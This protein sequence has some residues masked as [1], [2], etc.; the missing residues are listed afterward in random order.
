MS[1]PNSHNLLYYWLGQQSV[2][3][4]GGG[5]PADTRGC[6]ALFFSALFFLL[7]VIFIFGWANTP[8]GDI[9]FFAG[10]V[11]FGLSGAAGFYWKYWSDNDY[12][13][14]GLSAWGCFYF[15]LLITLVP[16]AI[17]AGWAAA[18]Y[19][20]LYLVSVLVGLWAL[21]M[22]WSLTK[23]WWRHRASARTWWWLLVIVGF[24]FLAGGW[25]NY[26]NGA[27]QR[28]LPVL[29]MGLGMLAVWMGAALV[30]SRVLRT[31][32][33]AAMSRTRQAQPPQFTTD[34]QPRP[35]APDASGRFELLKKLGDLRV[36]GILT[37]EEFQAEKAKILG[38]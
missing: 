27:G 29:S 11:A 31:E 26:V 30:R 2:K 32:Q 5:P 8:H 21:R 28:V 37:E 10:V 1:D 6:A 35:E 13:T 4:A 33:A 18:V 23:I 38:S 36:Q 25:A 12:S 17:V 19:P 3:N 7:A 20:N 22:I 14:S 24:C 34:Q 15:P 9:A 16:A